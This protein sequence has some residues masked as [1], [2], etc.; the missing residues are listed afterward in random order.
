[1]TECRALWERAA[2]E[3]FDGTGHCLEVNRPNSTRSRTTSNIIKELDKAHV[4][5]LR[6]WW[7]M[8]L[9]TKYIE[10]SRVPRGLRI[11][12]LPTLSDMDPDLLE[13]WRIQTSDCSFKLM[14][15]LITQAKRHM[16]EQIKNIEDL[17]KE[18]ETVS[19]QE[20][21][22]QLLGKMEERITKQEEEIKARKAHKFNSDKL[23]YEHGRIY[24]FARKYDTLRIKENMNVGGE[25]AANYSNTDIS[26]ELGSS[27][28]EAPFNKLDF[29]GEMCLMQMAT[30]QTGRS[31]E[32]GGGGTR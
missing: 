14:G 10:S 32:R 4:L 7:E 11:L 27:A 5:E 17:M 24:T 29:Q 22:K 25:M 18:L 8:T 20:E 2:T 3:L 15:T 16:D 1:M 23:H 21:V 13:E 19:K 6:K 30:P 9:L 26:S 28:D 31:R 12:I